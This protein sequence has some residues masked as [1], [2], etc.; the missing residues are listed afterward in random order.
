MQ[1]A[2]DFDELI[3][4]LQQTLGLSYV[5]ISHDLAVVEYLC[6]R[7]A[8]MH[9]GRIVE[10]APAAALFASPRHACTQALLALSSAGQ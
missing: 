1:A 8:V 2:G 4:T 5:F 3:E 7:V 6:D 9:Q 10:S